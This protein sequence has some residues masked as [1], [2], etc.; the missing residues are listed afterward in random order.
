[1]MRIGS[2]RGAALA[3]L[4]GLGALGLIGLGA[5]GLAQSDSPA[6]YSTGANFEVGGINVDVV[7]KS[8]EAARYAG[9]RIAQ[10]KGWELL[11]LRFGHKAPTLSDG[12]LDGIVAAIVVEN[13]EVGGNR[14]VARLGVEFNRAKAAAILGVSAGQARSAPMLLVPV[15]WSGGTGQ[16]FERRTPWLEAWLRF[17]T[18]NSTVDYVRPSGTGPDAL[19]MNAGQVLRP[20]RGW[21]RDILAQYGA[22]N[23]LIPIVHLYRQWPGGPVIGEFQARWGPDDRLLGKFR[24]R[25]SSED[26]LPAL[27][28]EGARRIDAVY[29]R[30]LAADVI[31]TDPGL[32]YRPPADE[33]PE[34]DVGDNS[35][36]QVLPVQPVGNVITV[37]VETPTAGSVS[38]AEAALRGIPGVRQTSLSSLALGA[39]S[40]M[41]V[42]YD[43]DSGSLATALE[44]R[45]WQVTRGSGAIRIQ[46][47]GAPAEAPPAGTAEGRPAG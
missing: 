32:A 40:V 6:G 47:P 14:Y 36:S 7:S 23:V 8:S 18:G 27:L 39:I 9:W 17:R 24:L 3:V 31:G 15:M 5:I 22:S 1:M 11:G 35:L 19:L 34:E 21:W 44:A 25:V 12:A 4:A 16:T 28:D 46:R 41:R 29:Q 33:A 13:E 45:G 30:A 42:T 2:F 43:G 10:R 20:G 26:A 37:Q 38:N